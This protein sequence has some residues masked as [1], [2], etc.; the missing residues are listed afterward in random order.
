MVKLAFETFPKDSISFKQMIMSLASNGIYIHC[1]I[2]FSDGS[3]GYAANKK[4][5]IVL[6]SNKDHDYSDNW[7]FYEIPCTKAQEES[8]KNYF[9]ERQ[10]MKYNYKG[11]VGS[12]IT[13]LNITS[14]KS[15][16]C[17][18]ICYDAMIASGVLK[19]YGFEGSSL[20][21]TNLE[22]LIEK[23]KW[24]ETHFQA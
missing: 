7:K 21:P 6:I 19:D 10:N 14:Q 20:S 5:G 12:M 23:L 16:F 17:S 4:R 3:V 15:A 1:E 18:E 24:N 11:I 13:G 8:M 22:Q 2:H 9:I